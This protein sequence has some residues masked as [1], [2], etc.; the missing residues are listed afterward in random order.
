MCAIKHKA[1][2]C[3]NNKQ[4]LLR[5]FHNPLVM[6]LYEVLIQFA[7][8][9]GLLPGEVVGNIGLLKQDVAVVL[10]IVQDLTNGFNMP[11]GIPSRRGDPVFVQFRRYRAKRQDVF[12]QGEEIFLLCWVDVE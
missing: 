1:N 7:V 11:H 5:S 6:P 10:L 9:G 12:V 3:T 4:R 8:V 2:T